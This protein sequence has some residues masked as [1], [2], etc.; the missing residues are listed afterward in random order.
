MD[1]MSSS[2]WV[3]RL[4]QEKKQKALWEQKYL[5]EEEQ[6]ELKKREA[7]DA[8]ALTFGGKGGRPNRRVSEREAMEMR[9]SNL[10]I[11]QEEAARL[12]AASPP[13]AELNPV[14]AAR[15]RIR[16]QVEASRPRSHR[17]TGEKSFDA[18]LGDISPGLWTSLNPGYTH[19]SRDQ[20]RSSQ[21]RMHTY[22]AGADRSVDKTHHLRQDAFMAHADKCLQLGEKP[23]KSGGMKATPK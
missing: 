1:H 16:Q 21:Q 12:E 8:S 11:Q 13:A 9:L 14:L 4:K 17:L 10:K 2:I 22:G 19:A 20:L 15:E 23:F 6:Q 7:D 18:M 3:E 5:T